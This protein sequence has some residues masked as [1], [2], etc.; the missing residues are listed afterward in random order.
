[1]DDTSAD[2]AR[3]V[4][5]FYRGM[6]PSERCLVAASM[7]ETARAI[8]ESSLPPDLSREQRRLR[9][10]RRIYGTELSET[11]LAAHAS[12]PSRAVD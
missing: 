8:V 3:R 5:D 11:A 1:M 2:V 4:A 7:F 10:A 9:V 6:T 12:F